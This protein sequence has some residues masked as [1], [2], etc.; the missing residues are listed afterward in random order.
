M[1]YKY[2]FWFL[3]C[4][5]FCYLL[6]QK[7]GSVIG[8]VGAAK[9]ITYGGVVGIGLAV[10]TD[11]QLSWGVGL[12]LLLGILWTVSMTALY[13]WVFRPVSYESNREVLFYG[14]VFAFPAPAICVLRGLVRRWKTP[15]MTGTRPVS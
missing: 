10:A 5:F 1:R 6:A 2:L 11:G 12:R 14:L 7:S 13:F 8:L 9:V 4:A 15:R 3:F